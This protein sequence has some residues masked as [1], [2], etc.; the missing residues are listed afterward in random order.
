MNPKWNRVMRANRAAHSWRDGHDN[1]TTHRSYLMAELSNDYS[2][3]DYSKLKQ[4]Q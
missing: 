3:V 2:D 4:G 1:H